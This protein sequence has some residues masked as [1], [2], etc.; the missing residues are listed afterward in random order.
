MRKQKWIAGLLSV[1]LLMGTPLTGYAASPD[2]PVGDMLQEQTVLEEFQPVV[3]NAE[4]GAELVNIAAQCGIEVEA[5]ETK[6]GNV[7]EN[8][9]DQSTSTLWVKDKGGFPATAGFVLPKDAGKVKK[10]VAVFESGKTSWSVDMALSVDG[11]EKNA[12]TGVK[13]TE[14]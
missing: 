13:F 12:Q 8:L 7:K 11:V 10:V 5:E 9:V 6:N 14:G 4:A 1:A 3:G 2:V